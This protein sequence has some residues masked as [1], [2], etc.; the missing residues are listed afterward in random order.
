MKKYYPLITGFVLLAGIFVWLYSSSLGLTGGNFTYILDDAYI[1][2]GIAKNLLFWH[3]PGINSGEFSF[4]TSSPL[5]TLILYISF[6]LSGLNIFLPLNLNLLISFV[7]LAV[8]YNL[9]K[10]KSKNSLYISFFLCLAIFAAPVPALIFTGMEHLLHTLLTLG[11]MFMLADI[12]LDKRKF[13]A[14]DTGLG[15]LLILTPFITSVRYEGLFFVLIAV[16][17]LFARR[18]IFGAILI[19]IAGLIPP[20][21][22][23]LYSA[24]QG[25]FILPNSVLLKSSIPSVFSFT[26]V[27]KYLFYNFYP[28]LAENPSLLILLLSSLGIIIT[29]Y[30]KVQRF[31]QKSIVLLTLY[32]VLLVLHLQFAAT[33]W[34][35][36]YEA[37]LIYLGIIIIGYSLPEIYH[38]M[39]EKISFLLT[40]RV[41]IAV[42]VFLV[43][44]ISPFINRGIESINRT[45][46]ASANIYEQ[47]IAVS[48][49]IS[50]Y[51]PHRPIAI[52]DIG[53]VSFYCTPKNK[54]IDLWG[55]ASL[56]IAKAKRNGYYNTP[57]INKILKKEKANIAIIYEDWFDG[58][59]KFY[60]DWY[61][62]GSL[63]IT[64]NY[65][66][67]SDKITFFAKDSAQAFH[68][69]K[70][71]SVYVNQISNDI[72]KNIYTV[73]IK[74]N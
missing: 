15:W 11:G 65:T 7:M 47:Q 55:L 51:L 45:P 5:W 23:G 24:N 72:I 8:C 52:H 43:I 25:W 26:S 27:I 44:L 2:M 16:I 1:H 38:L 60:R 18:K 35:Y 3:V 17:A 36:R 59:L 32:I 67:G 41:K 70:D 68:I 62:C 42:G 53:A 14:Y 48:G 46:R 39:H 33:G 37:Y 50:T 63:R 74:E 22:L 30:R 69:S 64:S 49:F 73:P 21:L 10:E 6:L 12:I 66:C 71:L 20:I 13:T 29:I 57:F 58:N 19:L 28:N 31:Y 9:L 56:D 4:C 54:I 61:R 34:F 40:K